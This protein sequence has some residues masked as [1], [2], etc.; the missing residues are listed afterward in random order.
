MTFDIGISSDY[1]VKVLRHFRYNMVPWIDCDAVGSRFGTEIMSLAQRERA[2]HLSILAVSS[3][4]LA[5]INQLNDDFQRTS[6]LRADAKACLKYEIDLIRTIGLG[7]LAITHLFD[8]PPSKW[9]NSAF[10]RSV[11]ESGCSA[12]N[13]SK[14]PLR[15][16]LRMHARIG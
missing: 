13:Y 7:L 10:H 15:T 12:E 16:L 3:Y 2:I 4:Q 14:E 6:K 8:S 1:E 9:K 5:L 11:Y